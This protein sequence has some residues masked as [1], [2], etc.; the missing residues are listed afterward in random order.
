LDTEW[1]LKKALGIQ[2]VPFTL[3]VDNNNNILY[4]HQSYSDGDEQLLYEELVKAS[5]KK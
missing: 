5:E 4:S 3:I 1:V 2:N